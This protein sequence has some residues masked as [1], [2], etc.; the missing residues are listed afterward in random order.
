MY[1]YNDNQN[2]NYWY[3]RGSNR[4]DSSDS[5]YYNQP[6]HSP[7]LNER[8]ALASMACGT[9]AMFLSCAFTLSIALSCLG[10]LFAVLAYRKGRKKSPYL[11]NGILLCSLGML[12]GILGGLAFFIM[13]LPELMK[14]S[15]YSQQLS[16][17]INYFMQLFSQH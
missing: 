15:F 6:V 7:Y 9:A 4:Q 8:F 5:P 16:F 10:F 13:V 14:N 1:L 11:K 12:T 17:L 2:P 3:G